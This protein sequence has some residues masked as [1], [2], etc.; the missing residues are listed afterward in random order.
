MELESM[1]DF[2]LN[3]NIQDTID[4]DAAEIYQ[5]YARFLKQ[6]LTLGMFVP[7]SD[8]GNVLEEPRNFDGKFKDY[9][10]VLNTYL[11]AKEKVLF[12]GFIV[13]DIGLDSIAIRK[14][15]WII[16]RLSKAIGAKWENKNAYPNIESLIGFDIELTES[17]IKQIGL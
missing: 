1:T 8:E 10:K 15:G 12:K 7:S 4:K 9:Q 11:E 16:V 2:V 17:A 3:K 14:N 6:P 13:E 5:S